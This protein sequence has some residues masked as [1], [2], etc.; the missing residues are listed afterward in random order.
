[1]K[2]LLLLLS[3]CIFFI[4]CN[5]QTAE[6]EE[7]TTKKTEENV[8]PK[9][10]E[11]VQTELIKNGIDASGGIPEGLQVGDEAPMFVKADHT[12][13]EVDLAALLADGPVVIQF[14]RGQW[15]PYCTK[16]M[17]AFQDSL[18]FITEKGAQVIAVGPET[19]EN[20]LAA[21]EKSE[22]TY[23]LIPD[24]QLEI[25]DAYKVTFQVTEDYTQKVMEYAKTDLADNASGVSKLPVP[26]T[27][28]IGQ[29]KKVKFVDFDQNYRVRASVEEILK[30]L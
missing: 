24:Y 4:S 10:E 15:C 23:P 16:S 28:V 1:M 27:Y 25:L 29:D 2:N 20:V 21:V 18:S 12:G 22:A 26:A 14:Y 9:P 5:E 13:A 6:K 3:M 17:A 30:H 19:N 8:A 7:T 11:A